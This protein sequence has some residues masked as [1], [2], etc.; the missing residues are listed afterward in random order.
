MCG[1][2]IKRHATSRHAARMLANAITVALI[3]AS[4]S[5]TSS[6]LFIRNHERRWVDDAAVDSG[7]SAWYEYLSA[8]VVEDGLARRLGHSR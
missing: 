8:S 7:L 6:I 5:A 3:L 2:G 4:W 1:Y